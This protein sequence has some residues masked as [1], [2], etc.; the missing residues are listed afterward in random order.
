MATGD[1]YKVQYNCSTH[2][3]HWSFGL[4]VQESSPSTPADDGAVIAR[5]V[6]ARL[7][8]ALRAIITTESVVE[9]V[10]AWRRFPGTSL[11][12][13]FK[14]VVGTGSVLGDSMS[15][16]NSLFINLRQSAQDARFNGGINIAGQSDNDHSANVWDPAYLAGPVKTFTDLLVGIWSAAV[17]DSGAY[18]FVVLSKAFSPPQNFLGTPF[19]ITEGVAADRVLTQRRRAQKSRGFTNA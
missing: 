5:A 14:L 4:W 15:N 3:R 18:E 10:Q 19:D 7:S 8:D 9:G 12:G 11:P 16:D 6:N 17:G 13:F 2:N 1:L